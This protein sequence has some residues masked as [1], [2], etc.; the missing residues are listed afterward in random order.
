MILGGNFCNH[1]AKK[2]LRIN[3]IWKIAIGQDDGYT[4][5]CLRNYLYFKKSYKL[6]AIDLSK[7]QK[8]DAAAKAIHQI[9]FTGNLERDRS[10]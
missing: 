8:L 6:L 2:D 5:G 7:Q 4:T 9:N 1:P 10:R 3:N